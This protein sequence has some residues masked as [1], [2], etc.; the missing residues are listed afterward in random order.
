MSLPRDIKDRVIQYPQRYT[1]TE[2]SAGVYDLIPV[3]G[4]VT[5]VGTFMNRAYLK[6]I[7][8]E[9]GY[10][11]QDKDADTSLTY[12]GIDLTGVIEY[13]ADGTTKKND[14]TLTYTSEKLTSVV[15]LQYNQSGV[16][17]RTITETLGYTVDNL[18]SVGRVI[19]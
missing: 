9:L 7:E 18:T 4:T 17:Q 11:A 6:P 5:E 8:D 12:T 10:I 1:L 15:T 2:I 14:I 3:T 13:W 19:T 16:L